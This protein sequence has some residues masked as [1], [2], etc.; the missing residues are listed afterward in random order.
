MSRMK[1]IIVVAVCVLLCLATAG[2]TFAWYL[3]EEEKRAETEAAKV[4]APY[5][6][7]L[8]NANAKDTLQFAVG[9]LHP[10]ETKQVVICV[11]NKRPDNYEGDT[12]DMTELVKDSEF[13]YDLMLVHTDNLAVNYQVYPLARSNRT[14]GGTLPDDAIVMEDDT[15]D[16]YYW[17]KMAAPLEGNDRSEDLRKRVFGESDTSD[18]VNVGS[19]W[20]SDDDGMELAY[21]VNASG[22]GNYEYDYYLVEVT[23]KDI[24]NFDDYKK[25]TDLVYVVV[26]AKQ[27]RPVDKQEQPQQELPMASQNPGGR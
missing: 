17:T 18:I 26:N 25:E 22:E 15:K 27:P 5:N 11:S 1:K 19:Y 24:S 20:L 8:M 21:R 12:S 7:Y 2:G 16:L 23:W 14:A 9:N 3:R 4:M 13:G 6:L 10:G